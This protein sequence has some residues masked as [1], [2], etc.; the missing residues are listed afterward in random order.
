MASGDDSIAMVC[1]LLMAVAS[2]AMEQVLQGTGSYSMTC[3]DLPGPGTKP[4]SPALA[5]RLFS[6]GPPGK[7]VK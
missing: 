2:H 1:G 3:R 5:D 7:P 6:A 4:L